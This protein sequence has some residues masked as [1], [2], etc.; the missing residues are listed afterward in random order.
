VL[1]LAGLAWSFFGRLTWNADFGL[2]A[3]QRSV[4]KASEAILQK[5]PNKSENI[6]YIEA[7]S[8]AIPLGLDVFDGYHTREA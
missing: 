1:F 3:A 2:N 8:A 6:Y 4:Y 7:Y 5:F